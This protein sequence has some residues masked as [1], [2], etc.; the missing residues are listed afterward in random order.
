M[1]VP[2]AFAFQADACHSLGSP[3]MGQLMALFASRLTPG[4]P[5]A[6]R[7]LG[8]Q[9]D[10]SP[11]ADSVPLRL[12]GALH[13]LRIE[14]LAL[15][16]AYPPARTDDDTL[17]S[18]IEHAIYHHSDS[19]LSWL[20]SP[21]QTNEVRRAA[22]ILAGLAAIH[23]DDDRPVDLVELGASGGLNLRADRF[24]LETPDANLGPADAR[25]ILTPEWR[26]PPPPAALPTVVGRDG[27][28]LNPIEATTPEGRLRL[29]AY[30]WPDQADRQ[31]RTRAAIREAR[32]TPATLAAAD[33]GAWLET[34]LAHGNPDHLTVVFHTVAWQYFPDSTKERAVKAMES[35]RFPLARLA[36]EA[37]GGTGAA[38]MLTRYPSGD[39]KMLGR[40]DF[41]GRWIEWND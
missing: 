25:V 40:A 15:T 36:M 9:G 17:W 7:V 21:P 38:L 23:A 18:A 5:V 3:F 27:V 13:A 16:A 31:A 6:D 34:R 29:L 39:S 10:P 19:I 22:A 14:E 20:D 8:W 24:R 12:A 11:Y 4:T 33:A 35:S 32:E 41:H 30:L 26:G 37:D 2:Q 28:D 1:T